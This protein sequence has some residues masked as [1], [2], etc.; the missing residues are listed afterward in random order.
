LNNA[1]RA[2]ENAKK[3]LENNKNEAQEVKQEEITP[4]NEAKIKKMVDVAD[5]QKYANITRA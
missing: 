3:E 2:F 5:I 1:N 4:V